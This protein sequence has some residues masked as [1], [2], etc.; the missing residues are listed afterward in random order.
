MSPSIARKVLYSFQ[1]SKNIR[2]Y[3]V[4]RKRNSA[5]AHWAIPQ[6]NHSGLLLL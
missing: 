1:R 5:V 4:K 6:A 3:D 2:N